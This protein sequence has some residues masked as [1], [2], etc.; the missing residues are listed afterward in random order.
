VAKALLAL[1]N[2]FTNLF[3]FQ[4]WS[5]APA[6]P[7]AHTLGPLVIGA[8]VV[9]ALIIGVMARYGSERIRGH[10]IPEAIEAI[11]M[12]GS[13][14]EPKVALLKP[15]SAAISIGSG[16]PFGAEGPMIVT[17][18]AV[19]SLI[20]QLFHLTGPTPKDPFKRTINITTLKCPPVARPTSAAAGAR[21]PV[22]PDP[23]AS[24]DQVVIR[25]QRQPQTERRPCNHPIERIHEYPEAPCLV[26]ILR[27]HR[28]QREA[29]PQRELLAEVVVRHAQT[30]GLLEQH[31][32]HEHSSRNV[33]RQPAGLGL[34]ERAP[35]PNAQASFSS[36]EIPD[37]SMG[38]G[39]EVHDRRGFAR[40]A[41]DP[42]AIIPAVRFSDASTMPRSSR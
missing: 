27:R 38:V 42:R 7:A 22:R 6:S 9:G 36:R 33:N 4:T 41:F 29:G 26:H 10:G 25:Q 15:L 13:R 12:H 16:G 2:L 24:G 32:L 11:L 19:G 21:S 30:T 14:V 5:A 35:G 40:G 23:L 18:G 20:A 34:P 37:Q 28:L 3:F 1:I 31:E 8:P 17:G 39:D